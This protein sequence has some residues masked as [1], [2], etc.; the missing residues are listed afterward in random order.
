MEGPAWFHGDITHGESGPATQ[1]MA[2]PVRAI[3]LCHFVKKGVALRPTL[4]LNLP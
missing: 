2:S 4:N 1:K 3:Y